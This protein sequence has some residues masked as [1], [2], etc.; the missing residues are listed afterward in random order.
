MSK[1]DTI[2]L[3]ELKPELMT[4]LLEKI[5]L[6]TMFVY[7][8][9]DPNNLSRSDLPTNH[10]DMFVVWRSLITVEYSY[11]RVDDEQIYQ[12]RLWYNTCRHLERWQLAQRMKISPDLVGALEI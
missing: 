8:I 6:G 4:P 5:I 7:G 2:T 3:E 1:L 9:Y 12:Y 10:T 11:N